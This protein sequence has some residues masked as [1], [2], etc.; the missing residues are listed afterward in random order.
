MAEAGSEEQFLLEESL[1]FGEQQRV[2]A[3]L[4]LI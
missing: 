1:T 3:P 4:L 2:V